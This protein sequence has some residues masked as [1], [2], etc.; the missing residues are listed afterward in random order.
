M[1][2]PRIAASSYSNT[3]P[4]IWSFLYGSQHGKCE[5]ILDNAPAR[6]AELLAQGRVD[7][8]LTPVAAFQTIEASRLVP[9][10]CIGARERV[11]SVCLVTKGRPLKNV[12]SVA[13]DISSRTSVCL[14]KIVFREFLGFEPEWKPAEPDIDSMLSDSD[15]GLLIGDPALRLAESTAAAADTPFQVHDLA[16]LW[17][18]HTGLGFIFAMW[19][20]R[21]TQVPVEFAAVRDEGL[22]HIDE[23]AANY[24]EDIGTSAESLKRYLKENIIY[25]PDASM[26]SGMELFFELAFKNGLTDRNR[27]TGLTG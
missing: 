12:R 1:Q 11:R 8:A 22:A 2:G 9:G 6:S 10:V 23:I 5:L 13:L 16:G 3:A 20:D 14:T 19:M 21:G 18:E 25:A 17:N 7:A 15:C 24:T 27:P 26:L 4:L